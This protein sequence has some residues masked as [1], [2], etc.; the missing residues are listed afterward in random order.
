MNNIEFLNS[1][2]LSFFNLIRF[3]EGWGGGDLKAMKNF[4]KKLIDKT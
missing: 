1:I 2:I 4:E 3:S